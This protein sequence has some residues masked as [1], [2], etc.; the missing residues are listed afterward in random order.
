MLKNA[1]ALSV[2]NFERLQSLT[3]SLDSNCD[4]WKL[5]TSTPRTSSMSIVKALEKKN[6]QH[7]A[8]HWN[9]SFIHSFIPYISTAPL[10]VHYCSEVLPTIY[11]VGVNTPK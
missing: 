9:I 4:S 6:T 3:R 1:N 8:S 11:C 7:T 10:Q 5:F 2:D